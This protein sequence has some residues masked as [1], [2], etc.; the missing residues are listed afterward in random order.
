[1]HLPAKYAQTAQVQVAYLSGR[2]IVLHNLI[3][4]SYT[5]DATSAISRPFEKNE[6]KL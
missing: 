1:M 3:I 6:R 5:S 2:V 4:P